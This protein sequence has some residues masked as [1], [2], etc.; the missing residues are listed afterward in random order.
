M[1]EHWFEIE[2]PLP[3][4][5]NYFRFYFAQREAIE[6]VIY[7]YEVA[8]VHDRYDML[9]LDPSER[10]SAGMFPE[11]W[12]R[13]VTKMA[14]GTGKTKV[15]GLILCWSY[16][17]ELYEADSKLS[18]NFLLIAPNIIVLNRL[19]KDFE[20]LKY[21]YEDPFLP[22]NG[23]RDH[24]WQQDFQPS[25]HL[26][27]E[28]KPISRHGNIFLTNVHRIFMPEER[29]LSME[30][31]FLGGKARSDA[32]TGRGLDLGKVL[33][34][35]AIQDL[36][37][38]NDEAHHIH[39]KKLA[40]F[41]AIED[42][43]N[44]LKQKTGHGLALQCDVT[45]TPKQNNGSIFVQTVS[46]Y[47]LVEAIRQNVVKTPVLPDKES[48]LKIAE[49]ESADFVERYREHLNLGY[50][51]WERQYDA[52]KDTATPLLFIM[53]MT[54]KE[55]DAAAAYLEQNFPL[56]RNRVLS[57]HTNNKGEIKETASSKKAK[58]ELNRLRKAADDVDSPH[59]PYRA[60]TSVLMLREGWDVRNVTTIVGLRPFSAKSNILP[61]QAI[62]RGLRKMFSLDVEESLVV[63]GTPA[64]VNFIEELRDQG[65]EFKY[66]P[67]GASNGR[68]KS[69]LIVE[70]DTKKSEEELNALDIPLPVLKPRII[71]DY[72]RLDRIDI[73]DLKHPIAQCQD[74]PGE[75]KEIVFNNIHGDFD[76]LTEVNEFTPDWRNVLSF[77]T[78]A[79]MR[80]NRLFQGFDVL[81]PMVEDFVIYRLFG[82]EVD[83]NQEKVLKNLSSAGVRKILYDVF[84]RAIARLTIHDTHTT[85]LIGYRSLREARPSPKSEQPYVKASKSVFNLILGDNDME[86][87]FAAKCEHQ[88][89]DVVAFAK[90]TEGD[91]GVRFHIEYQNKKGSISQFYPDFFVKTTDG[92]IHVVETKGREDQNDQLK[93]ARLVRWVRDVNELQ[94]K[95]HYEPLYV[96][97]E[98]WVA[99]GDH[100][101]SFA[102]LVD[103]YK[104]DTLATEQQVGGAA[105]ALQ[106]R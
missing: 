15:L 35:D 66:A 72:N 91:G 2:H 88:F 101:R 56:L 74:F 55:A 60:I 97:W 49:V 59:S 98:D 102:D 68:P 100:A 58:E 24:N 64:F 50:L 90:N 54:T 22:E 36:V 52:L 47:P 9:R 84:N 20:G 45:A 1:L 48:R 37:V 12:T 70:I 83:P 7:L 31:Y 62:G 96:T 28:L 82:R 65:V 76:H 8:G 42:I 69:P 81:Y 85:E 34:S 51:E 73:T 21:F 63:V 5:E 75:T 105:G 25:L 6:S 71:R 18:R 79:I 30:D 77:Y 106:N 17:N 99:H 3:D 13:Y 23:W 39:D 44:N 19:R 29:K 53:A 33:R 86:R 4:G 67:M 61:E 103:L 92:T 41:Q 14:T 87:A 43:N 95:Y 80:S 46:D 38:L 104:A 11:R 93:I 94:D 16:F 78:D 89:K 32:D 26:Q 57:I 10:V 40:W 27:D